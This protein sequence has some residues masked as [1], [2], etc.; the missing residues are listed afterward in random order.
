MLLAVFGAFYAGSK[1]A[2]LRK[3]EQTRD[4]ANQERLRKEQANQIAG[5][6][7][8]IPEDLGFGQVSYT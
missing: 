1:A 8:P 6:V 3:V 5:W 2:D 4:K 7:G